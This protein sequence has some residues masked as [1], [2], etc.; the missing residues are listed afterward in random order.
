M[1]WWRNDVNRARIDRFSPI[2]QI[3]CQYERAI[4]TDSAPQRCKEK[5][6][7]RCTLISVSSNIVYGTV[8][9]T[10]MPQNFNTSALAMG[11]AIAM[12]LPM[13]P[14]ETCCAEPFSIRAR[15]GPS[16]AACFLLRDASSLRS[17]SR[18]FSP[19]GAIGQN[20]ACTKAAPTL[21]KAPS[22]KRA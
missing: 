19:V 20:K 13:R 10:I 3:R 8:H 21:I 1:S 18:H 16:F 12:L 9:A 22:H 17:D 2:R 11:R 4:C 6:C 7:F 5:P 14:A 15:C